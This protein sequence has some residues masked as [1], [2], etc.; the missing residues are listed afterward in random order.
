MKK[1]LIALVSC[2]LLIACSDAVDF[3]Q[4]KDATNANTLKSADGVG[5][6]DF[7]PVGS[8]VWAKL[9]VPGMNNYP[10]NN[11]NGRNMIIQV[12]DDVYCLIGDL[13]EVIYKL[14]NRTK[15]WEYFSDPHDMYMWWVGGFDYLYSYQ[16]KIYYGFQLEGGP[17]YEHGMGSLNPLTGERDQ[18]ADFPGTAVDFPT[19]FIAGSKGYILGG[20]RNGVAINQFWEYDFATNKWTNKG[21]LPEGARAGAIA[22]VFNDKVY[23]GLGYSTVTVNGEVIRRYKKDWLTIDLAGGI[24]IEKT[25]FPGTLRNSSQGFSVNNKFYLNWKGTTDFWE[26]N[27]AN[28]TWTQKDNLPVTPS[29]QKNMSV[30]ALGNV[31]YLVKGSLSQFWRYS[32]TPIVPV[33]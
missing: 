9:T 6:L 25:E 12:G 19:S 21:S 5:T 17:E 27:P 31:G 32:N 28:N 22:F 24:A 33:P 23:F 29:D 15:R 18:I 13:H 1:I 20:L 2:G 10:F 14:N 11:P 7:G 4:T 26:Y 30:F 8:Y 16:S 3:S